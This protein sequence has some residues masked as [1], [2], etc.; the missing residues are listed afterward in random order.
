LGEFTV[1]VDG[2][3][4][5]VP[6]GRTRSLFAWLAVHRGS[7]R[8]SEVAARFWPDILDA[9]AR[10]SLRTAIW[11]LRKALGPAGDDALIATH[12]RVGIS[13]GPSVW[14]DLSGFAELVGQGKL[15]EAVE[16]CRGELLADLDDDWVFEARDEH[17]D[18]LVEILGRLAE[19]AERE[20]DLERALEWTRRQTALDPLAEDAHRELIRRL[21][22]AGDRVRALTVYDRFSERLRTELGLAPSDATRALVGRLRVEKAP[23]VEASAGARPYGDEPPPPGRP[24]PRTH[25]RWEP[26]APFPVPAPLATARTGRFVGRVAELEWLRTAFQ[27]ARGAGLPRCAFVSG[28]AGIGKTRLAAEFAAELCDQ[29]AVALYGAAERKGLLAHGPFA[30][31]IH[32]YVDAATPAELRERVG[33]RDREL[34]RLVPELAERV[35]E[36]GPP[37]QGSG[38][39]GMRHAVDAAAVLLVALAREVP[40][41]VVLDDLQWAVEPDLLLLRRLLT[42]RGEAPLLILGLTREDELAGSGALASAIADLVREPA[43]QQLKLG[44]LGPGE[45]A[46]LCREWTGTDE[47]SATIHAESG[48]NPLFAQQML[49]DLEE[50]GAELGRER[51]P[52]PVAARYLIGQRLAAVKPECARALEIAAVVGSQFDLATLERISGLQGDELAEVL[53]EAVRSALLVEVSDAFERFSFAHALIR[54]ALVEGLTRARRARIHARVAAALDALAEEGGEAHL[55]ARAY[56][57]CAAGRAGDP[58]RAIG[59]ATEAAEEASSRLAYGEALDLYNSALRLLP[60]GDERRRGTLMRRAVAYQ[61]LEHFLFVRV[62]GMSVSGTQSSVGDRA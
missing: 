6:T 17:K 26:G 61:R 4:V 60:E 38:E 3:R 44:G 35:P 1:E 46:T 8:R 30:D 53:E 25:G 29:G 45:V 56:H 16:L 31:A 37:Q 39:A 52:V 59:L 12:D 21:A 20:G 40:L 48:G 49:R 24:A 9:S 15:A 50:P 42:P 11:A 23:T 5:E 54:E 10:A 7:H 62:H 13:A 33:S 27:E 55:A 14:T 36:L 28:E 58:E 2:Q 41:L 22:A 34:A 47:L 57:W 43:S 51:L 18:E 32:H 19:A